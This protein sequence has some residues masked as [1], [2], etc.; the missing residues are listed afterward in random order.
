[1]PPVVPNKALGPALEKG[2]RQT[3]SIGSAPIGPGARC[4]LRQLS[5]EKKS[6][7]SAA[8]RASDSDEPCAA[9]AA[10]ANELTDKP[11]PS[12]SPGLVSSNLRTGPV[13]APTCGAFPG[14]RGL[15]LDHTSF[16]KPGGCT[17][18][19]VVRSREAACAAVHDG[20]L[21]HGNRVDDARLPHIDDGGRTCVESTTFGCRQDL[22]ENGRRLE[23]G[24][25][26]D[27]AQGFFERICH[28]RCAQGLVSPLTGAP[29]TMGTTRQSTAAARHNAIAHSGMQRPDRSLGHP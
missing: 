6:P 13:Q 10:K 25:G 29:Q 23:A 27:D 4:Q 26:G 3:V 5:R 18:T 24:V 12:P 22:A 17:R 21:Q 7:E 19:S 1:M 9:A 8:A 28:N 11:L 14:K 20:S 15:F 2:A 16:S